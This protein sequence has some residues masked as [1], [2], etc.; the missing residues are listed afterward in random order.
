MTVNWV[1]QGEGGVI[2]SATI[3]GVSASTAVAT[4]W[5]TGTEE[6]Y[7]G[8][9]YA[10][11]TSGTTGDI[12]LN[13]DAN[14]LGGMIG[15]FSTVADTISVH[16]TASANSTV[17]DPLSADVDVLNTWFAVGAH[18]FNDST[19]PS[20]TWSGLTEAYDTAVGGGLSLAG[21]GAY[22]NISATETPRAIS[23]DRSDSTDEVAL[24]VASFTGTEVVGAGPMMHH[25]QIVG[26]LV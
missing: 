26:G 22:E 23:V 17:T 21:S 15:V 12:V 7:T 1:R 10:K 5:T 25:M 3:G 19:S 13:F 6:G 18:A 11:V 14:M 24:C 16:D 8:I 9:I 4:G 20:V 2:S